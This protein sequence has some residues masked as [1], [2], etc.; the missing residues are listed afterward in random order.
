MAAEERRPAENRHA[1]TAARSSGEPLAPGVRPQ[2]IKISPSILAADLSRLAD[3][4]RICEA[5]GADWIHIDV[6]DGHFVPNL[7]FGAPMVAALRQKTH[8]T[9]D[10]HLMIANPDNYLNDFA[11]AGAD[12]ITVHAEACT[13]LHRVLGRI[14]EL[15]VKAGVALNPATPLNTIEHVLDMADLILI[16]SVNPGFAGQRFLPLVL[17]KLE[18]LTQLLAERHLT[19]EV[20]VDGGIDPE[21]ARYVVGAG[22]RALV[23]GA[24]VFGQP[25]PA[26]AVAVIRDAAHQA[27]QAA[28]QA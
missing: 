27:L 23:A 2:A 1:Q 26:T 9:L 16:M 14:R 3:A 8:L 19:P 15:G 6:M 5:S 28:S 7:T 22:A 11:R 20:Q 17:P 21:T 10:A 18:A 24:A 13:H 25:H 12:I 4:V